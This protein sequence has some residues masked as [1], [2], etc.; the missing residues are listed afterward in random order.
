MVA[1]W[2]RR[3]IAALAIW[4]AV[5]TGV[6]RAD[7]ANLPPKVSSKAARNGC[8]DWARKAAERYLTP[9][10]RCRV[11]WAWLDEDGHRLSAAR[12]EWDDAHL[13]V[14]FEEP[15]NGRSVPVSG[16]VAPAWAR[17][18]DFDLRW[19]NGHAIVSTADCTN[20]RHECDS[21]E[22]EWKPGAVLAPVER[23]IEADV[24]ELLG[25]EYH[26]RDCSVNEHYMT[27]ACRACPNGALE[28]CCPETTVW[29]RVVYEDFKF[30]V[31]KMTREL[32]E[33]PCDPPPPIP[34]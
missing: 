4:V 33:E 30:R 19:I 24:S 1:G 6:A 7:W 10:Q 31:K 22:F 14:L 16:F 28:S 34:R 27:I 15:G 18:D 23:R 21:Y 26:L 5:G 17:L 25:P 3:S 12:Y 13:V 2:T 9:D 32:A 11:K 20:G 8:P 29:A